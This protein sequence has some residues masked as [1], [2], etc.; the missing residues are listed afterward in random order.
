MWL[1]TVVL[2]RQ[3]V[4]GYWGPGSIVGQGECDSGAQDHRFAAGSFVAVYRAPERWEERH[5]RQTVME[6]TL[7]KIRTRDGVI[8][9]SWKHLRI[10]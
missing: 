6:K 3:Q 7:K 9:E 8:L 5:G 10:E 1:N 4:R 2:V